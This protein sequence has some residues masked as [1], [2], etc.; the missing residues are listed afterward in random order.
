MVQLKVLLLQESGIF[1]VFQFLMVQL[2]VLLRAR[3]YFLFDRVS[4]PYGTIKS[5]LM[6][7]FILFFFAVSIP[8]GTI[9][10]SVNRL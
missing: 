1:L 6:F 10:S 4:I 2:K 8:Y 3:L 9:K 5:L 7:S